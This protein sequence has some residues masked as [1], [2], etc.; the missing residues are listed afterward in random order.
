MICEDIN[1]ITVHSLKHKSDLL[2]YAG[3]NHLKE[4]VFDLE[5]LLDFDFDLDLD[6]DLGCF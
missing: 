2:A 6:Y 5:V 1:S 4:M 3:R